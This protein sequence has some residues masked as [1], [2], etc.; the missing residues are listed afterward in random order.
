MSY[1]FGPHG[2]GHLLTPCPSCQP[3]TATTGG[4][5]LSHP[6]R[7]TCSGYDKGYQE[8]F[9]KCAE[10]K[11]ARISELES[12]LKIAL[13]ALVQ[14]RMMFSL[15]LVEPTHPIET[16]HDVESLWE[17]D[18]RDAR[19]AIKDIDPILSKIQPKEME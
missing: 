13:V 7:D 2:W 17:R 12:K 11:D 1:T 4:I 14:S 6:C 18:K 16:K 19:R 15:I 8:G 5:Q 10:I 3:Q 9:D